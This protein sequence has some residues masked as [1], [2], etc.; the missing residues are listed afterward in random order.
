MIELV[1]F[2]FLKLGA[3]FRH[4]T[5]NTDN[6]FL[7]MGDVRIFFFKETDMKHSIVDGTQKIE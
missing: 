6:Y 2:N 1:F 4:I 3:L 5:I 7:K